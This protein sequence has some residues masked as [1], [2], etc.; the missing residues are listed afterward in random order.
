MTKE[1]CFTQEQVRVMADKAESVGASPVLQKGLFTILEQM[2]K[3]RESGGNPLCVVT[4][5]GKAYV[6][7]N[8]EMMGT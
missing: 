8:T 1:Y 2:V 7:D 6:L 5:E 3:V 4:E